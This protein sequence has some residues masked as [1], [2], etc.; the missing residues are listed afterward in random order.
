[1]SHNLSQHQSR[2]CNQRTHPLRGGAV[3]WIGENKV[4]PPLYHLGQ[5]MTS[6]AISFRAAQIDRERIV[7]FAHVSVGQ[8]SQFGSGEA[9]CYKESQVA[10]HI[11]I[12]CIGASKHCFEGYP[13]TCYCCSRCSCLQRC[14]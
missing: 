11:D 10:C 4:V 7:M 1:M 2:I 3:G 6:I 8:G 14:D 13:T 5:E 12:R 9:A